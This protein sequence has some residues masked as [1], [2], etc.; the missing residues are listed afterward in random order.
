MELEELDGAKW[1]AAWATLPAERREV[2]WHPAYA[3]AC[4]AWERA[5][6]ACLFARSAAGGVLLYP[7]LA[8]SIEGEAGAWSTL[9]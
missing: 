6:A 9:R 2:Y 8:H 1:A 4:A 3:E 5:A 7:Y